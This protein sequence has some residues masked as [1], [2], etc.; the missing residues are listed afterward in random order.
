FVDFSLQ[1]GELVNFEPLL[2]ISKF[3]F[4]KRNLSHIVFKDIS[5]RLD[6]EGDKVIIHPM[7]ISSSAL[8]IDIKGVYG[9]TAGTDIAMAIPLRNPAKDGFDVNEDIIP[10]SERKKKGITLYLRAR[11]DGDGNV[12]LSWYPQKKGA[13][14]V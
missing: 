3:A 11:D 1:N 4:K 13:T 8:Y 9:F 12:K 2:K 5:N 14:A 10:R 7:T 6:I